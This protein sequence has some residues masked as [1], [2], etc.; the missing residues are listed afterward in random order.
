MPGQA[1]G[2]SRSRFLLGAIATYLEDVEHFTALQHCRERRR[3]DGGYLAKNL[4]V[5]WRSWEESSTRDRVGT[6]AGEI[7]PV[8][9]GTLL[10][11][12]SSTSRTWHLTRGM[13]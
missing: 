2:G 5:P 12:R 1:S 9:R 6:R 11:A 3:L 10:W 4:G 8:P 7:S 13:L